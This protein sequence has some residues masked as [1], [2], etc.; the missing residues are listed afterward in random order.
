MA[1]FKTEQPPPTAAQTD[2]QQPSQAEPA[3]PNDPEK[4]GVLQDETHSQQ[5]LAYAADVEKRVVRKLDLHV[6]PIV[7]FLCT[8]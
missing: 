2:V 6:T 8:C 7:T 5:T 4:T 3:S 1:I